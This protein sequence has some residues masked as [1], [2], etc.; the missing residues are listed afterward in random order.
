M[1]ETLPRNIGKLE[2][3]ETMEMWDNELDSIPEEISQL[4][5]LKTLE[6]RGILFTAEEQERIQSLLPEIELVMQP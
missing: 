3:L 5:N 2:K 4:K 6:L 1:I